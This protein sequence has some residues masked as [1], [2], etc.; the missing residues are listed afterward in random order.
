VVGQGVLQRI[1]QHLQALDV[2][3][4]VT[5]RHDERAVGQAAA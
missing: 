4:L 3:P 2:D 1:G 5:A